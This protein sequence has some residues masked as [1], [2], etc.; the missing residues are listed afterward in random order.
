MNLIAP[1]KYN[2]T[3]EFEK[4]ADDPNRMALKWE[5]QQPND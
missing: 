1:E 5:S 3:S 4:Y 2:L